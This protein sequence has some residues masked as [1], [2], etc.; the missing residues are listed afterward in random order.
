MDSLK[1]E[2]LRSRFRQMRP[3]MDA[4]E[5]L[6]EYILFV[7]LQVMLNAK[8]SVCFL[9]IETLLQLIIRAFAFQ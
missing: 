2:I 8:N 9:L 6:G 4:F 3:P 7:V 1:L 5:P